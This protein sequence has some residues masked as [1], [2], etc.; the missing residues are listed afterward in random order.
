MGPDADP[1]PERNYPFRLDGQLSPLVPI[2]DCAASVAEK[3]TQVRLTASG[4]GECS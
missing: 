2:R 1:Y 3:P 4:P